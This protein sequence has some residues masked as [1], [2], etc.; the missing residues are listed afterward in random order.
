MRW[1]GFIAL[2]A[3]VGLLAATS[4]A[5]ANPLPAGTNV[6]PDVAGG[7]FGTVLA[8]Q[9]NMF[10]FNT[11]HGTVAGNY[12]TEV[13]SGRTGNTLGGLSFISFFTV[14]TTP[15]EG[16]VQSFS[17]GGVPFNP[18]TTGGFTGWSVDASVFNAGGLTSPYNV[19]RSG[20]GADVNWSFN[21]L[22]A[23]ASAAMILDTNAP[24]FNNDGTIG[25]AGGGSGNGPFAGYQ[26]VAPEPASLTLALVGLPVLGAYGYRRLRRGKPAVA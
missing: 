23:G 4:L 3:C 2:A 20:S 5:Q 19:A 17:Q 11:G 1:K 13:T 8:A 14:T 10:F 6:T 25:F 15:I 26:P 16:V 7:A 21:G 12:T 24:A 9:T 18:S 22:A